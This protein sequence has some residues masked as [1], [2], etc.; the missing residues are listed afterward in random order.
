MNE[1]TVISRP[2]SEPVARVIRLMRNR[3][4]EPL[5]LAELASTALFSQFHFSR[6]FRQETGV[7]PGRYLAA[8]RMFEAKRL[9]LTTSQN[10]ADISCRV[11]YSSVGTF[12]TRFTKSV[13]VSPNRY[14]RLPADSML[15]I[16]A[17]Y[18]RLPDMA[19]SWSATEVAP[20]SG[21][22]AG[23]FELPAGAATGEILI[24]VFAGPIPQSHPVAC[25]LLPG[26]PSS[27]RID[28]VPVG[29]WLV[30]ALATQPASAVEPDRSPLLVG[31]GAVDVS[32]GGTTPVTA[33][34][35]APL[36]TDPPILL[37][38]TAPAPLSAA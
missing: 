9:L 37:T 8:I 25:R 14:R 38:V 5:S 33:R 27:C 24:G 26:Q 35:R 28:G 32:P 20:D 17:D 19:S 29:R 22:I 21:T 18:R 11:G 23:R 15:A 3:F 13:G 6:T 1:N 10:V 7:S 16:D 30:L 36:P 31:S 2:L 12:T 34:M 4:D